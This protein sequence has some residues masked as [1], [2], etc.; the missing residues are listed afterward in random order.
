MDSNTLNHADYLD[1]IFYNR[2]KTYGGYQLRRTYGDRMGKAVGTLFGI[3]AAGVLMA[4]LYSPKT[5]ANTAGSISC[6]MGP[7]ELTKFTEVNITPPAS[8]V[9]KHPK[10]EPIKAKTNAF[11]VP[12]V[13]KDPI[14]PAKQMSTITDLKTGVPGTGNEGGNE[15]GSEGGISGGA[16][17]DNGNGNKEPIVTLPEPP[18][19]IAEQMPAYNGDMQKYLADNVRYPE[20]A[21]SAGIEGRVIVEFVVDEEGRVTHA[22]V[23]RGIGGGCD[24]EALR[25]IA[26]MPKWKPGKQNGKAVKVFF[27]LA[28]KFVLQ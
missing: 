8:P 4:M 25:V 1:V 15:G 2:N 18:R 19:K 7:I 28:V 20:Q 11:T 16:G 23:A 21:R 13:T 3:L 24:E 5:D 6:P 10:P 22:H 12:V 17:N 26:A 14:E 9:I 27:S